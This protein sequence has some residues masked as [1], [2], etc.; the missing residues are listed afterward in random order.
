MKFS[1]AWSWAAIVALAVPFHPGAQGQDEPQDSHR[2]VVA[3]SAPIYPEIAR[4][5]NLEGIVR[6]RVTVSPDGSTQTTEVLG[7]NPILVKSAQ[8]AVAHWKWAPS[9]HESKEQV[10]LRFHPH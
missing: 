1:S 2:K 7:G 5:M 9:A 8:D 6:L 10:E 3:R 4:R